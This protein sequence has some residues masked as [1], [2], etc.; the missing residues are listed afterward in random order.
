M[1]LEPPGGHG[2]MTRT[3]FAGKFCA[4]TADDSAISAA[5]GNSSNADVLRMISSG[6]FYGMRDRHYRRKSPARSTAFTP[7]QRRRIKLLFT[8]IYV[9]C[10]VRHCRIPEPAYAL[11]A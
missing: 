8:M 1:S 6:L 3:V 10:P 11:T 9:Q 2:T 5:I 7:E 4:N